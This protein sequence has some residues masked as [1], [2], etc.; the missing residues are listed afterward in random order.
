MSDSEYNYDTFVPDPEELVNFAAKGPRATSR[1]PSFPLED[2][3]TGETVQ[4][5]ELWADGVAIMEF[6]SF[7]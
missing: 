5:E 7:T 6:G 4:M 2:L 1:A 3:A